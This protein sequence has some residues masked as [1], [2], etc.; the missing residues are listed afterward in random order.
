M[1][2]ASSGELFSYLANTGRFSEKVTRTY[3]NQM[4]NGL[5]YLHKMGYAHR[6]LKPENILLSHDFVL[7]VADFGFATMMAG[8]D[9]SG[10]LHTNLGS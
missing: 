3:F 5:Y 8:R 10:I 1:E 4:M 2:Y 6:D 7:K 9:N